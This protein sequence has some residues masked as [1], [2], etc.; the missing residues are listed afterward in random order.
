MEPPTPPNHDPLRPFSDVLR[1]MADAGEL[2]S[3]TPTNDAPDVPPNSRHPPKPAT[4]AIAPISTSAICPL[5]RGGGQVEA[6]AEE[7]ERYRLLVTGRYYERVLAIC[8]AGCAEGHARAWA[9]S[10]LPEEARGVRL[11]GPGLDKHKPAQQEAIG[12]IKALLKAPR[13]WL[14]LAGG[15]GTGKTTLLYA[16]LNHLA[17]AGV[18]GRYTTAPD[19][20]DWLRDAIGDV[21]GESPGGR[22]RQ[23]RDAPVL[24]VDELDKYNATAFAEEAV[25]KLFG[26]RY[27]RRATHITLIGYNLDGAERIPPFLRSRIRDG[28][29]RLVEMPGSDL[30]P[31]LS[32]PWERGE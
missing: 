9:W 25:L 12:A 17:G 18:Y 13:G 24:A 31:S 30:R 29:F 8:P 3:S 20:L 7:A 5:C 1:Q 2:P 16:T 32:D 10:G 26:T 23:L 22:L 27:E 28:R 21:R 19:L 11:G 4:S 15:Y 6:T 14:T